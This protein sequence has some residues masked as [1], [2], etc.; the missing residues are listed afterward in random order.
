MAASPFGQALLGGRLGVRLGALA[1][2]RWRTKLST[3]KTQTKKHGDIVFWN[4][5]N[6]FENMTQNFDLFRFF[7]YG[8][9]SF[10]GFIPL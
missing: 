3:Q 1:E 6:F 4:K 7:A 8:L 5:S 2:G 10:P 9:V